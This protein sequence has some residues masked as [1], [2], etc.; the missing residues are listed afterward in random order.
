MAKLSLLCRI[1]FPSGPRSYGTHLSSG[2]HCERLQGNVPGRYSDLWQC[3]VVLFVNL[4]RSSPWTINALLCV[5]TNWS[6]RMWESSSRLSL[7]CLNSAAHFSTKK[8]H[9]PQVFHQVLV[10]LLVWYKPISQRWRR[11]CSFLFIIV[12]LQYNTCNFQLPKTKASQV[13]NFLNELSKQTF[14]N[15][16][17]EMNSM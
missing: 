10:D 13:I 17:K 2:V 16:P 9:P 4:S 15:S 7:P 6:F 3:T 12:Y 11:N 1:C 14:C 5:D 8:Q